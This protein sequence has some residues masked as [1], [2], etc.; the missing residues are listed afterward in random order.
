MTRIAISAWG[1][2]MVEPEA[3]TLAILGRRLRELGHEIASQDD[4]EA[5]SFVSLQHSRD[6]FNRSLA[7]QSITRRILVSFEPKSVSP[8]EFTLAVK[9]SYD[10]V[11][12]WSAPHV[13]DENEK[14]TK[15][16]GFWAGDMHRNLLK[17][18]R[19]TRPEN[20]I[21]LINANKH[22][23]ITGSLYK[24]R[25][26]VIRRLS[27]ALPEVMVNVAGANWQAGIAFEADLQAR[28]LLHAAVFRQPIDLSLLKCPIKKAHNIRFHGEVPDTLD[29]LSANRIAIVI[30]NEASYVS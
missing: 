14:V 6:V 9:N 23:F 12:R 11:I 2:S 10:S 15:F 18:S 20:S 22:S 27:T 21:G 4:P 5:E 1:Q 8:M 29:F 28:S 16:G 17:Y 26:Q 19:A 24:L 25:S 3:Q 30:E 7:N 13:T